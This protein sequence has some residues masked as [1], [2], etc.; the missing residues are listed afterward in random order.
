MADS[1]AA[2]DDAPAAF[3]VGDLD[4]ELGN[5]LP[6]RDPLLEVDAVDLRGLAK[7]KLDD[8]PVAVAAL[9]DLR[10][11]RVVYGVEVADPF[12]EF[13]EALRVGGADL[14][15]GV[16]GDADVHHGAASDGLV[17]YLH[18]AGERLRPFVA[19][20]VPSA[21]QREVRL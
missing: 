17:V 21:A 7:R 2:R 14:S 9:R 4:D 3:A 13:G 15:V 19:V 1:R 11:L 12:T 6:F 8:K 16:R 5:P 10:A 20:P 18:K